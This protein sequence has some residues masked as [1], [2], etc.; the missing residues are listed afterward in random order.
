MIADRD[1]VL[2]WREWRNGRIAPDSA[3]DRAIPS[4]DHRD[5]WP[6]KIDAGSKRL[7]LSRRER[8][9]GSLS[10]EHGADVKHHGMLAL[11][12]ALAMGTFGARGFNKEDFANFIPGGMIGR[13]T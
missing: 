12:D 4:Q 6:P 5:V 3:G 1:V 2:L 11:G 9:A 8:R 10:I 13:S 7:S